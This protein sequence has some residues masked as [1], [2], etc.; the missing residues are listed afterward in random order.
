MELGRL[1]AKR[2]K[3]AALNKIIGKVN[4]VHMKFHLGTDLFA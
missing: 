1:L 2:S 3:Q 4:I